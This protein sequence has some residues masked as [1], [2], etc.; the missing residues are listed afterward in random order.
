MSNESGES[1]ATK[2]AV[3]TLPPVRERRILRITDVVR[4][5]GFCRSQIYKMM[6][7]GTFPKAKSLGIRAVGWDSYEVEQWIAERLGA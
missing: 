4:M 2:Q 5:V 6:N 7:K 3:E 1:L